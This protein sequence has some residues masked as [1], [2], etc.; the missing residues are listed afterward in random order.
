MDRRRPASAACRPTSA[1][2]KAALFGERGPF[3]TAAKDYSSRIG[4]WQQ[5]ILCGLIVAGRE[6]MGDPVKLG[7]ANSP[8]ELA[9]R[10]KA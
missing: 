5:E 3:D 9:A 7:K 4:D 2:G 10:L 1:S 6:N 8:G